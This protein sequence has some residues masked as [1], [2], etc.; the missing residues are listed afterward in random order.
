M[1]IHITREQKEEL[2]GA[3]K[4]DLALFERFGLMDYS[5]IVGVYRPAPGR[6]AEELVR[7]PAGVDTRPLISSTRAVSDANTHPQHLQKL[8][9]SPQRTPE[10]TPY[11][12]GSAYLEPKSG[13]V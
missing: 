10:R 3:I 6:A 7:P 2:V 1:P 12:T 8:P 9:N 5:M 4:Q 11:P 13:R